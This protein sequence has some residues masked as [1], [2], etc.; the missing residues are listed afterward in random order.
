MDD[1][2]HTLR[3]ARERLGLTL[4]EVERGTR[5]RTHHLEAMERG[6][7]DSLP[8]PVQARGFLRNYADFIGLDPGAILLRYADLIQARRPSPPTATPPRTARPESAGEVRVRRPRLIS[9]DIV[10]ASAIS[11]ALLVLLLWG[12]SW[13]MAS[14][15][16]QTLED[17]GE[18]PPE[19]PAAELSTA[20]ADTPTPGLPGGLVLEEVTA[21]PSITPTLPIG[22]IGAL[23]LR[24]AVEKDAFLL[25]LVDGREQMR[26]RARPGEVFDFQGQ[27][28]I[29]VLT[30]NG[31]GVRAIFNGNDLGL[32]GVFDEA[33]VRL[34]SQEGVLTPTPTVTR[35]PAGGTATATPR[36]PTPS[37]PTAG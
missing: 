32:M 29:E 16:Q 24:L 10:I 2:G 23:G 20:E 11:L 19:V 31:G 21:V 3:D 26:Q 33:V 1:L 35:T 37:P 14:L 25:V 9:S 27:S 18:T 5:I 30:G 22:P 28:L 4:E 8:S 34:Y 15:R 12:A 17:A 6:D 36:P 7:W 13:V